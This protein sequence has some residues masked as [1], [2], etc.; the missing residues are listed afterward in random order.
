MECATAEMNSIL[1]PLLK[2]KLKESFENI[3]LT[4]DPICNNFEGYC[5]NSI[6]IPTCN[7]LSILNFPPHYVIITI[8]EWLWYC[9]FAVYEE[10]RKCIAMHRLEQN[11]SK[12]E[13]IDPNDEIIDCRLVNISFFVLMLD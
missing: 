4:Y 10:L 1:T 9:H 8:F 6:Y 5:P 2:L 7:L 11:Y 3:Y 13:K 12:C